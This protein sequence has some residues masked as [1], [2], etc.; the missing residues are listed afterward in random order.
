MEEKKSLRARK[1]K[2]VGKRK[3]I[4]LDQIKIA[5]VVAQAAKGNKIQPDA[6]K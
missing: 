6:T 1:I 4:P 2:R 3:R 5:R